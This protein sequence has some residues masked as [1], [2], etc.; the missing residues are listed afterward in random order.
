M[1]ARED[2]FDDELPLDTL[3]KPGVLRCHHCGRPAPEGILDSYARCAA[4]G[5]YLHTCYNCMFFDGL[6]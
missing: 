5:C 3:F 1:A 2:C 6:A 4:C